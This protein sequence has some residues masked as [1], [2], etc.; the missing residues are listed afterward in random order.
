MW[1]TEA[2]GK[3]C[4]YPMDNRMPL[5]V[6]VD[7]SCNVPSSGFLKGISSGDGT[8]NSWGE[9]E[10]RVISQCSWWAREKGVRKESS[11]TFQK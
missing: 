4:T 7:P 1:H 2:C 11:G 8:M 10:V 3:Q 5:K 6:F 9:N